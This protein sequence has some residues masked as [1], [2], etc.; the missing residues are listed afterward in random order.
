MFIAIIGT[1]AAGKA[2]LKEYLV[3][4]KGFID[5]G[6]LKHDPDIN[7]TFYDNDSIETNE[8]DQPESPQVLSTRGY[9]TRS[10]LMMNTPITATFPHQDFSSAFTSPE[11]PERQMIF[12]TQA[13]LLDY[14]TRKWR[15]DFV[16]TE[17]NTRM[18][19]E[20]FRT[21]PF[22]MVV[23]VDAPILTRYRRHIERGHQIQDSTLERFVQEHDAHFYGARFGR[24]PDGVSCLRN[25]RALV[26]VH[27][28]N[29]FDT[30]EDLYEHLEDLDIINGERLRPGWDT[31]FMRLADLAS[32][33][34]NCMKRRVGAI[35]VRNNRILATGYNGTPRGLTNCNEGGC[36][37]CN[38]ASE[39]SDECVCLHAEENALLEAGR[40][41]V[42]DGSTLYCNTCPCLKCTIKIIQTGVKEVVYNLSY[43]VD[44]ASAL[45]FNEAGVSLRRYASPPEL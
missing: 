9:K 29:G 26:D 36:K 24:T 45:L 7:E 10:F 31:Y 41:R 34:S 35:L 12:D 4:N 6:S 8:D 18:A 28:N 5:V 40:E 15:S 22:F 30:K 19:L 21:R 2:T 37:R 44:D 32:L 16:T 33:R 42:G 38:S 11:S 13:E 27:V 20:T 25:L 17:L 3:Q 14:V 43:K 1:R 23:S 39:I